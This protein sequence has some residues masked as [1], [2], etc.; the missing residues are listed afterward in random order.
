MVVLPILD[1]LNVRC[2]FLFVCFFLGQQLF[3]YQNAQFTAINLNKYST[4]YFFALSHVFDLFLV[5]IYV[6]LLVLQN[7]SQDLL[8]EG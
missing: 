3:F 5:V 7:C 8:D 6:H 4:Q 2:F 1:T